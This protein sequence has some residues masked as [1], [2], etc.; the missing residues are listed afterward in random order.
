MTRHRHGLNTWED[1][2]KS[3]PA[4]INESQ[5][6]PA[7]WLSGPHLQTV[8]PLFFH[9]PRELP[10]TLERI[11]LPDGAYVGRVSTASTAA[12]A[13]LKIRDVIV[14]LAGQ[15]VRTDQDIHR[16]MAQVKHNQDVELRVWR[17]GQHISLRAQ[18]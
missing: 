12:Y 4:M 13:G 15:P 8:W 14:Q 9:R 16:I 2:E 6:R 3:T 1:S 11:E 10:L 17:N 7:R 18:F 5:F